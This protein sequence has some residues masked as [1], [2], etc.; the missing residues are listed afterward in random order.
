MPSTITAL[1]PHPS[2]KACVDRAV[3]IGELPPFR[4]GHHLS[5]Q[6]VMVPSYLASNSVVDHLHNPGPGDFSRG[7]KCLVNGQTLFSLGAL[8]VPLAF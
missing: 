1:T 8:L 5:S 2:L 7:N 6:S 4:F 3:V